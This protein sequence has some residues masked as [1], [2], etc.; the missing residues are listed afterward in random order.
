MGF[1]VSQFCD[2]EGYISIDALLEELHIT[3]K[4]LAIAI[5]LSQR[6]TFHKDQLRSMATQQRL[7]QVLE[8]LRRIEPWAGSMSAAWSWYRTYPIAAFGD[9]TAEELLTRDRTD[10]V[11]S[12]LAH[13]AEGGYT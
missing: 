5:G 10:D 11:R 4:E 6:A 3:G 8:I 9:L 13:I 1:E 2:P 12:Y 7:R